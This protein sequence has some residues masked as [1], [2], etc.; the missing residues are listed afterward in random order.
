VNTNKQ[1]MVYNSS[2]VASFL[3]LLRYKII[4]LPKINKPT[5]VAEITNN[6]RRAKGIKKLLAFPNQ[7]FPL[8]RIMVTSVV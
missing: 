5:I 1:P 2:S 7:L 4:G 3:E 6:I 8:Y